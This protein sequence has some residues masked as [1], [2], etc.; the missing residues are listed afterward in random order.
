MKPVQLARGRQRLLALPLAVAH[1][2]IGVRFLLAPEA[3]QA[4]HASFLPPLYAALALFLVG[5]LLLCRQAPFL[6][7]A[8][9]WAAPAWLSLLLYAGSGPGV[10]LPWLLFALVGSTVAIYLGS[11]AY[12][13]LTFL[14]DSLITIFLAPLDAR[15]ALPVLFVYLV[16]LLA[17]LVRA[18]LPTRLP[19]DLRPVLLL[20]H[21][22]GAL[23]L[24]LALF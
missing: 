14:G 11:P 7:C 1:L 15:F 18:L 22:L 21:A 9:L 20:T 23:L 8:L 19:R 3:A 13:T 12:L 4:W 10:G 6:P 17:A 2:V 5:T 24:V 16:G